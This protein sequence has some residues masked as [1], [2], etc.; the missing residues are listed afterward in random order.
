VKGRL[1]GL[2]AR[3]AAGSLA[4]VVAAC[5]LTPNFDASYEV[6]PGALR[7][8]PLPGTLVVPRFHEERPPRLWSTSGKLFLLYIPFLPWVSLPFERVDESMKVISDGIEK[9]GPGITL[10]AEVQP[11]PEY[12]AYTYPASFPRA[13]ARDI[14]ESGLFVECRYVG[15]DSTEGAR[16]VLNGSIRESPLRR[17]A[18]SFGLGMAGVLLWLLPIP[19]SKTTGSIAVDLSLVDQKSGEEIWKH[20]LESDVSRYFML[21]TSSAMVYG[22]GGA[23]SFNLEPPPAEAGVDRRSLF[24]WH[25]AALRRAMLE[26]RADLA[27]ALAQRE[28]GSPR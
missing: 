12:E 6:E 20:T 25:F 3:L 8:A 9:G 13:I 19:M 28:K 2:V 18:T 5:Q 22:R 11:G 23:F 26:A 4:L 21:Y 27:D 17:S 10:G 15:D 1:S 14:A 16:Y 7:S 24:S